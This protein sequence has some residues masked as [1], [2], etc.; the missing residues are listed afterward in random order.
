[1]ETLTDRLADLTAEAPNLGFALTL[2]GRSLLL[3][4]LAGGA[5]LLLRRAAAARRHLVLL[6]ALAGLLLLLLL[7]RLLPPAAKVADL[8]VLPAPPPSAPLKPA[9]TALPPASPPHD[10]A[11]TETA[12]RTNPAAAAVAAPVAEAPPAVAAAPSLLARLDLLA[13]WL[14]AAGVALLLLSE[15]AG[16]RRLGRLAR[17]AAPVA[18]GAL[19]DA[20]IGAARALGVRRPVHLMLCPDALPPLTFGTRRPVLLLPEEARGWTPERLR[21]VL[22]HE[23]AHIARC[24]ALSQ[25]FARL[26]CALW[27]WHP[28]AWGLAR[29]LR[30]ESERACDDR[31]L[32]SGVTGPEY[33][34]H[35]VDLV[36]AL[37]PGSA[38]AAPRHAVAMAQQHGRKKL[39]GRGQAILDARRA[40][41]GCTRRGALLGGLIAAVLLVPA[42]VLR[43][44]PRGAP[45]S[46]PEKRVPAADPLPDGFGRATL[47]NGATVE[48]VA[49]GF[50]GKGGWE[51]FGRHGDRIAPHRSGDPDRY[52][53]DDSGPTHSFEVRLLGVD[54]VPLGVAWRSKSPAMESIDLNSFGH[55]MTG[56][57]LSE[58]TAR[59][60]ARI[61]GG[62]SPPS[63]VDIEYGV[64]LER[65]RALELPVLPKPAKGRAAAPGGD[66]SGDRAGQ[67]DRPGA[68]GARR[69]AARRHDR[70]PGGRY[71][72][73]GNAARPRVAHLRVPFHLPG[74]RRSP[75]AL[76]MGG[77][78]P[79]RPAG[80]VLCWPVRAARR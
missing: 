64:A 19:H 34:A 47:P 72:A 26:V 35:L 68:A 12:P 58:V 13:V 30:A 50:R 20:M 54:R 36:R 48:V 24:D 1:M 11:V 70:Y 66:P 14:Y 4:A 49:I 2:A 52:R 32:L 46:G 39:G 7:P 31:V 42:A 8:P 9:Q 62:T 79:A 6:F 53:G 69:G 37:R 78:E 75:R 33:A 10:R 76:P 51:R 41:H 23:M 56:D 29:A 40:R 25:A 60:V 38:A 15:A 57:V 43:L 18:E 3:F 28:L 55:S 80:T 22:L 59:G 77:H 73:D 61:P 17:A 71:P 44:T 27:W 65:R 74:E 63:A 21:A 16:R 67:S 5:L 45:P